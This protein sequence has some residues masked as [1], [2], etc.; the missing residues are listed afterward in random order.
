MPMPQARGILVLSLLWLSGC[1]H[2]AID[3]N[4][5]V[6]AIHAR[7]GEAAREFGEVLHPAIEEGKRPPAEGLDV[8]MGRMRTALAAAKERSDALRVPSLPQAGELYA[9]HQEFLA[10]QQSLLERELVE[11]K[12]LLEQEE[13]TVHELANRHTA[14]FH[15]LKQDESRGLATLHAAQ[16]RFAEANRLKL[17][18]LAE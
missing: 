2:E 12:R 11:F 14:R 13:L 6:A 16:R 8:A 7:L 9:A 17:T 5:E 15:A 18:K 10:W 4:N 3:F 1:G